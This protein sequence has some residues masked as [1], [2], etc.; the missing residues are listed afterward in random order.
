MACAVAALA[1]EGDTV[2]KGASCVTKSY[3]TFFD[4][5]RKLGVEIH[6]GK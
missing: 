6:G 3:P 2:L 5:L 1:A 4:D